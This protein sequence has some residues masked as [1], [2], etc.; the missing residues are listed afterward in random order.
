MFELEFAETERKWEKYVID[1][2]GCIVVIEWVENKVNQI[3]LMSWRTRLP[4]IDIRI[5]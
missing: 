5:P 3:M 1:T 2:L 4:E